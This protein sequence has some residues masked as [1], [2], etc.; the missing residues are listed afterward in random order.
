ML[1]LLL[2]KAPLSAAAPFDYRLPP[3]Q[4]KTSS[5]HNLPLLAEISADPAAFLARLAAIPIPEPESRLVSWRIPLKDQRAALEDRLP[6]GAH[7]GIAGDTAIRDWLPDNPDQALR[8]ISLF[9][10]EKDPGLYAEL[11]LA[12]W[13]NR[14]PVAASQWH[15]DHAA[16]F[17]HGDM[18]RAAGEIAAQ[19][20]RKDPAAAGRWVHHLNG[21]GRGH[22]AYAMATELMWSDPSNAAKWIDE[23]QDERLHRAAV[24]QVAF[25]WLHVRT[26][27]ALTW[28]QSNALTEA[29]R[30]IVRRHFDLP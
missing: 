17:P 15:H 16:T 27:D 5:N 19:W 14:D 11:S 24:C 22:A 3:W 8:N 7:T 6:S 21:D 2:V 9:P 20:C 23:I 12:L 29:E 1:C 4:E 10:L 26:T 28:I 25:F 18:D 30:S 13:A